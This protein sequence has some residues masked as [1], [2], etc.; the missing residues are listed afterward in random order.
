MFCLNINNKNLIKIIYLLIK[1]KNNEIICY[2]K[3]IKDT[4]LK[5]TQFIQ[6]IY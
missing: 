4:K 6:K 2:E 5:Y 3:Y 1:L